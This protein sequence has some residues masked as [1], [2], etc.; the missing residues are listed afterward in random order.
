MSKPTGFVG[1]DVHDEAPSAYRDIH[2]VM[3]AQKPLTRI[4]RRLRPVLSFQGA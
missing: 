2:S 1:L 4:I 3:R